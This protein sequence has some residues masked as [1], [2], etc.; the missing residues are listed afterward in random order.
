[1]SQYGQTQSLY[2]SSKF[3]NV[4]ETSSNFS[5]NLQP[6]IQDATSVTL[7]SA[8]VPVSYTPFDQYRNKLSVTVAGTRY[9]LG[10]STT[11]YYL[12]PQS[13]ADD[14]KALLNGAQSDGVFACDFSETE[15]TIKL[16][17]SVPFELNEV[18][19]NCYEMLGWSNVYLDEPLDSGITSSVFD[20][21]PINLSR[22]SCLYILSNI[23]DINSSASNFPNGNSILAKV[24]VNTSS[25]G[26]ISYQDTSDQNSLMI[27]SDYLSFCT[28]EI[29]DDQGLPVDLRGKNINLELAFKY[30]VV[31]E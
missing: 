7:I 17:C 30:N 22:T 16:T 8:E 12:Q 3:R 31:E 9:D 21:Y 23:A 25:G 24:P 11:H 26:I 29:I 27:H 2:I 5:V 19:F 18:P 6:A 14:I 13:L 10:L 1:M 4:N 15:L 28:F 20:L